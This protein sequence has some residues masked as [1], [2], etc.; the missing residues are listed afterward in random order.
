MAGDSDLIS[1]DYQF[2][3]DYYRE[4]LIKRINIS[5]SI[6]LDALL[7]RGV[8]TQIEGDHLKVF[9]TNI[10]IFIKIILIVLWEPSTGALFWSSLHVHLL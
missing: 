4:E 2:L 5:R 6:L 9:V 3:L 10:Y 1:T 7:E 8:L